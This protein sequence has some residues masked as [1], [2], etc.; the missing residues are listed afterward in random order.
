MF[1]R[2]K[3]RPCLI[4][5][6]ILVSIKK[7][8]HTICRVSKSKNRMNTTLETVSLFVT[9]VSFG[10][11]VLTRFTVARKHSIKFPWN[12][13]ISRRT[14]HQ[15]FSSWVISLCSLCIFFSLLYSLRP[16]GDPME[17]LNVNQA[18]WRMFTN[19][20]L[21]AAV[22]LGQDCDMNLRFVK[23]YLWKTTGQLSSETE[24]L[25]SGQT[26]STGIRLII[27]QDLRWVS[28][29]LLH[30]RAY[31]YSTAQ[32]FVFSDSVHC[33]GKMGDDAVESRKSK[34]QWYSDNSY[35]SE[36]NRID[37][38]L[39]ELE[40]KIFPRFTAVGILNQIQ[41]MMGESQREPENFSGKIIIM[42]MCN[43][44]IWDAKGNDELCVND[45]R[46]INEFAEK[47]SSRS[48]SFL[49]PGSEKKC[50]GG[51][52][53]YQNNCWKKFICNR[54][55]K[56]LPGRKS[57][58]RLATGNFENSKLFEG[59]VILKKKKKQEADKH[60][61]NEFHLVFSFVLSSHL[62]RLSSCLSCCLL[63]SFV[64]HL[65]LSL[66]FHLH[67]VCL[68]VSVCCGAFL[69]TLS[70]CL[71]VSVCCACWCVLCVCGVS[72][73]CVLCGVCVCVCSVW[74]G[75][76]EKPQCVN[77]KRPRM[78]RHAHMCYHMRAWCPYTRWRFEFTR[79]DFLD[80][81]TGRREG[82]EREGCHRQ[83][84]SPKFAPGVITCFREVHRKKPLDLT[85]FQFENRSTT[86]FSRVLQSFALPDEAVQ[87]QLSW[88]KQ[89]VYRPF[90]QA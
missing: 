51:Q 21:R 5:Q 39:M 63:L 24:K 9:S 30:S 45:S 59:L 22:R 90:L 43:G 33:L 3:F 64:L 74:C 71:S 42:S 83:F 77:S 37:G 60:T 20:T 23:S 52:N 82:R 18:I 53:D 72:V 36:L 62:P 58:S 17:D 7:R 12:F 2:H 89:A 10:K 54:T 61:H 78:Y 19:T 79:G 46:T 81:H 41:L 65:L 6:M 4:K 31:Q 55:N 80:G 15:A 25:I 84:C 40:W 66:V 29:S 38:Q 88:G 70:V 69:S 16:P 11:R 56:K 34:F 48:F 14:D 47:D 32:V 57:C 1:L 35:F 49:G 67:F 85:H 13:E 26:E 87:F 76:Q 44:I 75:T 50:H 27:F 28:T 68:S 8:F 73:S 86:T